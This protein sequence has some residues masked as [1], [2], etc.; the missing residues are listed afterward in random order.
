MVVKGIDGV[1]DEARSR[2]IVAPARS[3]SRSKHQLFPYSN[4]QETIETVR[5]TV[6]L[7]RLCEPRIQ[8]RCVML[9]ETTGE[10]SWA[11]PA[12]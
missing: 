8:R 4:D 5:Y 11:D 3:T 12:A 1:A 7:L 9:W 2:S 6:T 10:P